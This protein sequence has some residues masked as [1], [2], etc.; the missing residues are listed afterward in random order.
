MV[1]VWKS[2]DVDNISFV[3]PASSIIS[4]CRSFG[5]G[6]CC[7]CL[8]SFFRPVTIISSSQMR[9][10]ITF[11]PCSKSVMSA[12]NSFSCY[13][14]CWPHGCI[15][16]LV[17]AELSLTLAKRYNLPVIKWVWPDWIR[18]ALCLA[19]Q[20]EGS[21]KHSSSMSKLRA[22]F[23]RSSARLVQKLTSS[24]GSAQLQQSTDVGR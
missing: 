5:C 13:D 12:N 21:V 24:H 2:V 3:L 15:A 14:I 9:L 1:A 4:W 19:A 16:F 6:L 20:S 7:Y 17:Q 23:M 11:E 10:Y 22:S 8:H 18:V